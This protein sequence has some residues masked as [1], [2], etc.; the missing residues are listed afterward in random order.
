MFLKKFYEN[1]IKILIYSLVFF[2]FYFLYFIENFEV[3]FNKCVTTQ[4]QLQKEWIVVGFLTYL[5]FLILSF[6]GY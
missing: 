6:I 2:F 5:I 1:F 4:E 3:F